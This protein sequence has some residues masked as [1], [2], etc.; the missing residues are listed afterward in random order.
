MRDLDFLARFDDPDPYRKGL[1]SLYFNF[2]VALEDLF[3]G[4]ADHLL[5]A[6]EGELGDPYLKRMIEESKELLYA[7][8]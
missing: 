1:R 6:V 8:A 7:A 4:H 3:E 5:V 2:I